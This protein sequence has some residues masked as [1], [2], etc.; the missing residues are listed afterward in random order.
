MRAAV[1]ANVRDS[2][3][4]GSIYFQDDRPVARK[5]FLAGGRR[6]LGRIHEDAFK[7]EHFPEPY[8][9]K[10]GDV[11]RGRE[12]GLPP[13]NSPFPGDF[14]E[15]LFV[16]HADDPARIRP[17]LRFQLPRSIPGGLIGPRSPIGIGPAI[18]LDFSAC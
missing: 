2:L 18:A 12:F 9:G 4:V 3:Y 14:V 13:M 5:R 15:V 8:V 6:T 7:P 16:E 11:L 17:A 1:L 10:I